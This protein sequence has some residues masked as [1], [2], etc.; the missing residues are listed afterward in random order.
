MAGKESKDDGGLSFQIDS[1]S[2]DNPGHVIWAYKNLQHVREHSAADFD[3]MVR[4]MADHRLPDFNTSLVVLEEVGRVL[5]SCFREE[6]EDE[7]ISFV[8]SRC[9]LAIGGERRA[10]PVWCVDYFYGLVLPFARMCTKQ[11]V[12]IVAFLFTRT[13]VAEFDDLFEMFSRKKDFL[14]E[15]HLLKVRL[16]RERSIRYKCKR[17]VEAGGAGGL[18]VEEWV[19]GMRISDGKGCGEEINRDQ[20]KGMDFY[21]IDEPGRERGGADGADEPGLSQDRPFIIDEPASKQDFSED[22]DAGASEGT[23]EV[24]GHKADGVPEEGQD[25]LCRCKEGGAACLCGAYEASEEEWSLSEAKRHLVDIEPVSPRFFL[26]NAALYLSLSF[27]KDVLGLFRK[28][29]GTEYRT[30]CASHIFRLKAVDA[31][32]REEMVAEL[33][34]AKREMLRSEHLP[35][36]ATTLGLYIEWCVDTFDSI[37]MSSVEDYSDIGRLYVRF[38]RAFP[39]RKMLVVLEGIC[40]SRI[41]RVAN[42]AG[43]HIAEH[44][45]EIVE[46]LLRSFDGEGEQENAKGGTVLDD[47]A[48]LGGLS[49]FESPGFCA[50]SELK[51]IVLEVSKRHRK[52]CLPQIGALAHF[53]ADFRRR[54]ARLLCADS[55]HDWRYRRELLHSYRRHPGL[56][57]DVLDLD[58]LARDPV[59]IV[60]RT[61]LDIKEGV[62]DRA[63]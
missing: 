10:A 40:G 3:K 12:D 34:D 16:M 8:A 21:S 27:D 1:L 62:V 33:R 26:E 36:T 58:G 37:S 39:H 17:C 13:T 20:G 2:M 15:L 22:R 6:R 63:G 54:V 41:E 31:E 14:V 53:D 52:A 47:E 38:L 32:T 24:P 11:V 35:V 44:L 43:V 7:E 61:A 5:Q 46:T 29:M 57:D 4:M 42:A 50:R 25:G 9:G 49:R 28:Y 18:S 23:E 55:S 48:V 45:E 30:A 19:K 60:R 59:F 56:L 51:K